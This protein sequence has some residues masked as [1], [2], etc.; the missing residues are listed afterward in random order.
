MLLQILL[1]GHTIQKQASKQQ[2]ADITDICLPRG[3]GGVPEIPVT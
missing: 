3:E 1:V 2:Q